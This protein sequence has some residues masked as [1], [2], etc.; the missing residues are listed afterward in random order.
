MTV[1]IQPIEV[2]QKRERAVVLM[3]PLRLRIMEAAREPASAAELARRLELTPQKVNYHV[4]RLVEEGFLRK[5]DE[6]PVGNVVEKVYV[7]SAESFVLA[8]DILGGLSPRAAE[9]DALTAAGWLSMQARAEVELGEV[10]RQT[11]PTGQAVGTFT[12]D[13]EFRFESVEQRALFARALRELVLAAVSKYTSPL[14]KSEGEPGPGRP[15]R[16]LMGCYPVPED[17]PD[18]PAAEE[19]PEPGVVEP[20]DS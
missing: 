18:R 1:P 10:Y 4:R 6:R 7:A 15:Y 19:A 20:S 8:T 13:S 12:L 14:R 3:H 16:L 11:A 2:I 5:V 17:G 9:A